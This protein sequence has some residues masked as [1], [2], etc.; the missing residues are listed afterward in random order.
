VLSEPDRHMRDRLAQPARDRGEHHTEVVNAFLQRLPM[1][2]ATFDAVVS[3]VGLCSVP[4]LERAL[5]EI[6]RVLR[7]GGRFVFLE[8]GQAIETAGFDIVQQ[9]RESMRKAWPLVRPTIR[10]HAIKPRAEADPRRKG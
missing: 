7:P 6:R 1:P 2:D 10:G 4:R 9:Q 3:T 8:T 5:D